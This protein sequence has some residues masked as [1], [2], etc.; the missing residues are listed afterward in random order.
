[1]NKE[2]IPAFAALA[3]MLRFAIE[4]WVDRLQPLGRE[5][6]Q[7]RAPECGAWVMEKGDVLMFGNG[8]KT[9][10][11]R[12]QIGACGQTF[13]ALAEGLACMRLLG[14]GDEVARILDSL[15]SPNARA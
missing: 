7:A 6:W 14:A 13:N 1:M 10:P 15:E 2:E 3:P 12:G 8:P 4:L 9:Q 5:H 11:K